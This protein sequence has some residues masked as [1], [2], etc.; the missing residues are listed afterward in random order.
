MQR[1]APDLA[2]LVAHYGYLQRPNVPQLLR[3]AAA[4]GV[5]FD[6]KATTY[7]LARVHPIITDNPGMARWRKPL[8]VFLSNNAL[9]ASSNYRIPIE[10]VFEVGVQVEL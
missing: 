3:E 4:Q 7:F 8:Y 6:P 9:P 1:P 2:H 10:Q 5:A